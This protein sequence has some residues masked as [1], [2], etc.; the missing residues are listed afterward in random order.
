MHIQTDRA[1]IPAHVPS[2]RHLH[3]TITAPPAKAPAG[4]PRPPARV[5]LVLD[6]SGSMGGTKMAMAR[7]AVQHAIRLLKAQD[8]LAVVCYDDRVETILAN[9]AASPEAKTLAL[10]RLAQVDARGSTNLEGG[11]LRGAQE[12][13]RRAVLAADD[14]PGVTRVLLLTD[15]LA[16]QGETNPQVLAATAARLR[17]EGIATST[18]GV[19]ADFDEVLLQ[20]LAAD[21]GGHF[22]FIEQPQQIPD[23]LASELGE[24][25]EVVARDAVFEI[26]GGAGRRAGRAERPAD[27]LG[28]RP[29]ARPAGGSGR[30]PGD[31]ARPGRGRAPAAGA[32]RAR[33]SAVPRGGPRPRV[34]PAADGRAVAGGGRRGQRRAAGQSGRWSSPWRGSWPRGAEPGARRQPA[35]GLRRGPPHPGG[36]GED[37]RG[38][39]MGN[40]AVAALAA[41]LEEEQ[42]TSRMR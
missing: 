18:F 25:L 11:W 38:L 4:A 21:G 26:S 15:G 35:R 23:L 30:R 17:A 24:T 19:G 42:C 6:R 16:N 9:T 22:Y 33:G 14:K 39:A 32:G 29:P 36:H 12:L 8:R 7:N 27:G 3:V 10:Q 34:L 5:A 37:A 2:V 20:R 1:L 40:E 28:A 31:H 41:G 13:A